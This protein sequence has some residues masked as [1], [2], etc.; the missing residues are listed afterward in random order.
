MHLDRDVFDVTFDSSKAQA[1]DLVAIIAEAGYSARI[2][3][4]DTSEP[5]VA[6]VDYPALLPS[7]F[8][9]ARSAGKPVVLYFGA[10]WCV[11]CR[12]MS[13]ETFADPTVKSLLDRCIFEKIDADERADLSK[14]AGARAL[15]DV[16]FVSADGKEMKR[17]TSFL[18]PNLFADELRQ[19]L[20]DEPVDNTVE[21]GKSVELHDLS[22]EADQLREA[23][24]K[25]SGKV[26]V[27]MLV[28]P[29]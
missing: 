23:F 6:D 25:A 19:L 22:P 27:V 17:I 28:S 5:T 11:P 24:V 9:R 7:V 3:T 10:S 20:G 4:G 1:S 8:D 29:G 21:E 13:Q 18:G 14:Q 2:I 12:R 16:R 26:R 15:P